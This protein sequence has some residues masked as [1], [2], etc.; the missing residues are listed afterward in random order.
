MIASLFKR[1]FA[2]F[3]NKKAKSSGDPCQELYIGNIEYHTKPHE[4]RKLFEKYGE[5]EYLKIIRDPKTKRSKGYGFVK[6]THKNDASRAV[7][8]KAA[9]VFRGRELKLAFAKDR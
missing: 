5:I 7:A 1:L 8:D 6:F 2:L 9:L 3:N 4:L